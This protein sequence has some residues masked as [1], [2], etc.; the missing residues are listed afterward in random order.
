MLEAGNYDAVK[1][2]LEPVQPVDIASAIGSLPA[3]T[4]RLPFVCSARTKPSVFTNTSTQP[5]TEPSSLLRPA[6]A[7]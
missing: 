7:G 6:D 2:L 3:S 5:P 1:L 4:S